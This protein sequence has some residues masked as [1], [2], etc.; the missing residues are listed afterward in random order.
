MIQLYNLPLLSEMIN[1]EIEMEE[2]MDRIN[3]ME[4]IECNLNDMEEYKTMVKTSSLKMLGKMGGLSKAKGT[5]FDRPKP[6]VESVG[7]SNELT[8][9]EN[10]YEGDNYTML[11]EDLDGLPKGSVKNYIRD[12]KHIVNSL[13]PE[14]RNMFLN[15]VK[16]KYFRN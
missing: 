9:R 8:E 16:R 4:C 12:N 11:L 7:L 3:V 14:N 13:S 1:R 2:I 10:L 15:I 6:L 5:K